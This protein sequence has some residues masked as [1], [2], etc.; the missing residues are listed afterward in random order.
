MNRVP[1]RSRL[2][3]LL[4]A[5]VLPTL[6]GLAAAQPPSD[7]F[8][9]LDRDADGVV[10]KSEFPDPIFETIDAD[11][12]G[13]ITLE[14]ARQFFKKRLAAGGPPRL[15]E[16]VK[17]EFDLP[18]AGTD[19]PRQRLD[20]YLPRKPTSDRPLPVIAFI[21]GGG[22]QS[23]DK[24]Q[25][26]GLLAAF[27]QSGD[28]ATASIGY[29]LTGE[30][31]WPAQ[32]HDCKA[33]IRWLRANA[34][35]YHLDPDRIGVM[36]TSAGGH[37]VALLGTSGDVA[38]L[39]GSLGPHCDTSSRVSC[40][41]DQF[42]P[43]DFSVIGETHDRPNG[44]V[45]KL[46]GGSVRDRPEDA[47]AASP[48]THASKDDPP[49]MCVHGTNDAVV[50][51]RQSEVLE[52]A[53]ENAGVDCVLLKVDGGGHGGFR[54]PA[55]ADRIRKFFDNHLRGHDHVLADEPIAEGGR[56]GGEADGRGTSA[57]RPATPK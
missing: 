14:E 33:A 53:L 25:A 17:A 44:P 9:Q 18:Y 39:E 34:A 57:E 11:A 28:Y 40:V 15:P 29:R 19:N 6:P 55:V 52:E 20:L 3:T 47:R 45:A 2:G 46:L 26:G 1:P 24:R 51:F 36:G 7:R 16:S 21:H 48:V 31:G 32:I 41:V 13:R 42:G 22:W 12:N 23:G 54:N 38:A 27:A 10:T 5:A 4:L 50:P 37:L 43:T 8:R 56:P 49:F 30:V 35:A